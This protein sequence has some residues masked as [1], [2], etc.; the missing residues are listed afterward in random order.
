M[1]RKRFLAW[2]GGLGLAVLLPGCGEDGPAD[3]AGTSTDADATTTAPP[4]PT[5][6]VADCVLTPETTE[7]PYYL[8]LDRVRSDITEGRPGTP[9]ELVITVV[10]EDACKPIKDAAVD[11]WHC[12]A[13]GA[14]SGVAGES[15]IFLRGTQVTDPNG[16]A[17]FQTIFPGWYSGRAVHIHV[18]VHVE[19]RE[20]YT[21]Q[22]F[23]EESLI[24]TVYAREPYN[25]RPG[26]DV[27]NAADGLFGQSRGTTI[28]AVTAGGP[29]HGAVVLGVQRA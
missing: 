5:A 7:G 3:G 27:S 4:T 8:D 2:T 15:G 28:V 25:A 16:R 18:K 6:A 12:D 23:F 9:L 13:G 24:E 1:S 14:Y 17:E 19:T 29:L 11:V 10:D 26:P 20:A 22:L 21:G